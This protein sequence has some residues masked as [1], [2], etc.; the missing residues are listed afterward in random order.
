MAEY[1]LYLDESCDDEKDILCVAGCAINNS[2]INTIDAEINKIKSIIWST[3]EMEKL[4]PILHSTELNKVYKNRKNPGISNITT[5]AYT[6]F[7]NKND[8]EIKTIYDN[9]Y[10]KMAELIK[11]HTIVTFCC[12]IDRKKF[13]EYYSIPS[14]NRL[15]DDWYDIAMQ[16]ILE[17]Y[18]HFLCNTN[19]IG[20]VIYEAR[21]DMSNKNSSS[22]DN[23][24][25]HN[26]CKIKVNGK[27]VEYLTNRV[28]YERLRFL[29]IVSKKD[30]FS[31]LQIADFIAFNYIKWFERSESERTDF[32][33]RIHL[34]AY[35]GNHELSKKDLREYWGLKIIPNDILGKQAIEAELKKLKSS[36]RKE[37]KDNKKLVK[38][39]EKIKAEKQELE[40]KYNNLLTEWGELKR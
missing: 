40:E 22:L 24:M 11:K 16:E 10:A 18:T 34:A 39:L 14:E 2:D 12:I 28:I 37:K 30:N 31:G 21:N 33:K 15:F 6:V 36:F 23:K 3:E 13:K 27:G 29:N 1:T 20:S 19:G 5:G 25:F 32:M 8:K 35:N 9:V 17:A 38:K 7:N 26:F 4:S